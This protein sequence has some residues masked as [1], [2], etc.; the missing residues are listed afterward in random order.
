[1]ANKR[2]RLATNVEGSLYVDSTCINCDTCRQLAPASF[3]E[4]GEYSAVSRQ[5]ENREEIL[6]SYQALLACPVGSIGTLSPDRTYM[7]MARAGFPMP[8]E[9]DV[10]YCG[11]NSEKSYG[12]NS[13]LVRHPAGNWLI[14][15]PR[16]V[17]PLVRSFEQMGGVRYIFLTHEDDVAECSRY[18]RHFG[19]TRIIHRE[20][21]SAQ[22][23][24]EWVIDGMAPVRVSE[25]CV[26]LPT[27][28]HT[29][30]SM[31]LLHANRY[32]FTGDH[33]SWDR[34]LNRLRMATIYVW[35]ERALRR[36][37]EGLLNESFEWVLPGHGDRIWLPVPRMRDELQYLL[38]ARAARRVA[39]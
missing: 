29:A 8:I 34:D 27:P 26:I 18:A 37:T 9:Q 6:K 24:A 12:A 39:P 38:N 7:E 13:Y 11:Y 14:D 10:F 2:K 1:M 15:S 4:D 19:A 33:M 22:P 20:D 16:Y 21:L 23:D 32:L 35:S 31:M 36:S 3:R 28:G 25:D 5:P 17:Q 30:G